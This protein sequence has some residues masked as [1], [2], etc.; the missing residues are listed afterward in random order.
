M[1]SKRRERG[2]PKPKRK[3]RSRRD[4]S[5]YLKIEGDPTPIIKRMLATP[6]RPK[7]EPK[8]R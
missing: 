6:P 4:S 3:S 8:P 7:R 1:S 5:S 2:K